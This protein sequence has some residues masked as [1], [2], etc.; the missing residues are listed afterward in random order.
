MKFDTD[1]LIVGAGPTG[2]TLALQLTQLGI[3]PVIIDAQEEAANTSRAAVIHARTLEVL[4]P[5]GVSERLDT[6]GIR[7]TKFVIRD[8][9]SQLVKVDFS[10][11]HTPYPYALMIP[12]SD[13]E[14]ILLGRLQEYGVHVQ[15]PTKLMSL[16][17]MEAGCIAKLDNGKTLA[18]R[19]VVG[20]D[21][22]HSVVRQEAHIDFD[23]GSYSDS[24]VLADVVLGTSTPQDEINLYFS[25]EGLVVIAPLPGGRHRIVATVESAPPTP[26]RTFIQSLLDNRGPQSS[27]MTVEQLIWTSRFHVHHRIAKNYQHGRILLAGDSA[28]VHSPAGG[29]GMNTGI[30][31]AVLL[32]KL[33]PLSIQN[34]APQLLKEYEQKRRPVAVRVI[35]LSDR[36]TRL[37][38]IPRHLRPLRNSALRL[39][40]RSAGFKRR[41]ALQLA[42]LTGG[43]S[44]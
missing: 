42:G 25:S 4:E 19:Y 17:Q 3:R 8:R 40:M 9:D 13:T 30:Q 43:E 20:A 28:H 6:I 27:P 12:Q 35:A 7:A 15:R 36:L 11:L 18:A 21:G 14:R 22:M 29:Q 1:V 31:D 33:L 34:N 41:L 26:D 2:L 16:D 39:L 24:F 32:G 37:A 10:P 23:G 44:S 38:T 5:L